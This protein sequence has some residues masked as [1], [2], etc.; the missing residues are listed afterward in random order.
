V[1]SNADGKR[2]DQRGLT[3]CADQRGLTL[4]AVNSLDTRAG[5]HSRGHI[6]AVSGKKLPEAD[7]RQGGGD[8]RASQ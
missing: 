5:I 7:S 4:T 3:Q 2:A 1:G 8:V 6:Q